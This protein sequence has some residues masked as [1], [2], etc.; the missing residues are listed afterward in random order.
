MELASRKTPYTGD[1]VRRLNRYIYHKIGNRMCSKC[2]EVKQL[3][4]DN[5]GIHRYFYDENRNVK[6]VGYDGL[7]KPCLVIK[8]AEHSKRVKQDPKWYCRKLITQ[9][10]HR[11]KEQGVPFDVT[12]EYLYKVLKEQKFL[13]KH[14]GMVLDFTLKSKGNYPHRHFPSVDKMIPSYGYVKGNIAWVTYAIN[15]MKN[16]LTEHEFISFCREVQRKYDGIL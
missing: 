1:E 8:R 10:R 15:R 2:Q 6:N 14:T 5:F 13:C 9:L 11:A 12:A 7:C 4:K 3:T 16:D